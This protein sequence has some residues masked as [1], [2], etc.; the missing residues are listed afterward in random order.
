MR[1]TGGIRKWTD[2]RASETLSELLPPTVTAVDQCPSICMQIQIERRRRRRSFKSILAAMSSVSLDIV[3]DW[4][5]KSGGK[6]SEQPPDRPD[7][8][9]LTS[10]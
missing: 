5:T 9:D 7:L 8:I 4:R 3:A 10:N 6:P 2:S 1:L